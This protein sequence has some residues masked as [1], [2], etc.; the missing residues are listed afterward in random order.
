MDCVL[1][2]DHEEKEAE[3]EEENSQ[4]H[5]KI[6]N[7]YAANLVSKW[8]VAFRCREPLRFNPHNSPATAKVQQLVVVV[9]EAAAGPNG[10]STSG[11]V[12]DSPSLSSADCLLD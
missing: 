9:V 2:Y 12:E 8:M 7:I 5:H 4:D 6:M 1:F 10:G 11:M 3:A